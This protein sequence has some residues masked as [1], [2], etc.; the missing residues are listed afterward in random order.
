MSLVLVGC[1]DAGPVS[2]NW[3]RRA[4]PRHHLMATVGDDLLVIA[5]SQKSDDVVNSA[6]TWS[7]GA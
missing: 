3:T 7:L 1:S 6:D 2:E 5:G 4:R